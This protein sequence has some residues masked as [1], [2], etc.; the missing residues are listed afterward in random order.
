MMHDR[1]VG[2]VGASCPVSFGKVRVV[3]PVA[4]AHTAVV[5]ACA[6]C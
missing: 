2:A 4:S 1:I 5:G 3:S 6:T